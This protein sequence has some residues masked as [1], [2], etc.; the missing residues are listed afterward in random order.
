MSLAKNIK[1]EMQ[2][3]MM[4]KNTHIYLRMYSNTEQQSSTI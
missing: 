3:K 2:V 4:Y 1:Q